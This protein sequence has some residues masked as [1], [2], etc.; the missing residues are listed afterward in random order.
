MKIN[1]KFFVR[2]FC[3]FSFLVLS[4]VLGQGIASA[5]Q[6]PAG[7]SGSGLNLSLFTDKQEVVLGDTITYSI[8]VFNGT[9]GGPVVCNAMDLHAHLKTP[10][11]ANHDI[12]LSQTSL[13]GGESTPSLNAVTY[14]SRAEDMQANG[15][16]A[17]SA[18]VAG[19]IH[20]GPMD[21]AGGGT[22]SVNTRVLGKLHV[23]K[24]V[25][26]DNGGSATAADFTMNVAGTNVSLPSFPG[27]ETGQDVTLRAGA[28]TVSETGP[29]ADYSAA[30]SSD[31]LGTMAAGESKT[32]TITNDDKVLVVVAPILTITKVVVNDNGGTKVIAD[33]PLF[34]DGASTTSGIA[35]TTTIGSHKIS[36]TSD[37]GYTA[38]ISGDC[39]ADGAIT[40]ASGDV[41]ACTI[42]NNDKAP[43]PVEP[44]HV[45]SGYSGGAVIPFYNTAVAVV[46][47]PAVVSPLIHLT[48]APSLQTLPV[49]GGVVIYTMQITNPGKVAL[50]NI[51]L[52]DDKCAPV[53]YVSGDINHDYK[54]D[55]T[56]TFTYT[57]QTNLT[58]TTTNIATASGEANGLT[59]NSVAMATVTVPAAGKVLGIKIFPK[60]G[61]P[62]QE[63]SLASGIILAATICLFIV[64]AWLIIMLRRR[65]AAGNSLLVEFYRPADFK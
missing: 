64:L 22:Q 1:F 28:Y 26:N 4:L 59:V 46:A 18:E 27:S 25:I 52:T 51:K 37:S 54:L 10:D 40:L 11:G 57:C 3:I 36:E 39:A 32:C 35:S 19:T 56:E 47:T 13:A 20:F 41:K 14:V 33:F 9:G 61:L 34:I 15:T 2:T 30:T 16:L 31:C 60:A 5:H 24:H 12:T 45:V 42:T 62:P 23:I 58:K 53:Q 7:C 6:D 44:V 8:N 63:N 55:L 29:V 43:A 48:K 17:A 49:G 21:S 38:T 65:K 50:S